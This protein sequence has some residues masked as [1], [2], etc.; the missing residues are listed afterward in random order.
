VPVRLRVRR[1][2]GGA[3]REMNFQLVRTQLLSPALLEVVIANAILAHEEGGFGGSVSVAGEIRMGDLPPT[4]V[5]TTAVGV[6]GALPAALQAARH[7]AGVFA[8]LRLSRF[9]GDA[10]LAVDLEVKL[11]PEV[12]FFQV[13]EA[14]LERPWARAG[15][16][17]AFTAVLRKSTTGEVL[18]RTFRLKVPDVPPGTFLDLM[19]GD[20]A[21]LARVQ[22]EAGLMA[23]SSAASGMELSRALSAIPSN[24][25]LHFWVGKRAP[26][27]VIGA[28]PMPG[29]PLSV[30]RILAQDGTSREHQRLAHEQLYLERQQQIGVV[31]GSATLKLE[32]R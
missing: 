29:L 14:Q 10:D 13:E 31:S 2:G 32:V 4:R 5:E 28:R 17:V 21:A 3:V 1:E 6:P 11:S 22:G 30:A 24:R 20:G 26:G 7:A 16:S 25:D 27:L 19:V 23:V 12:N 18:R 9:A 8:A 15:E